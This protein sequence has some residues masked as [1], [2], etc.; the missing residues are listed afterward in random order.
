MLPDCSHFLL[1]YPWWWLP[2]STSFHGPKTAVA[3]PTITFGVKEG[4]R[5]K[6][7]ELPADEELFLLR[8][9]LYMSVVSLCHANGRGVSCFF[10]FSGACCYLQ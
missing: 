6:G 5:V 3:A 1:C 4:R 2:F 7:K 9:S 10:F 8:I